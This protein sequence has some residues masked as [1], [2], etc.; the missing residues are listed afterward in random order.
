[1]DP[2]NEEPAVIRGA[3]DA[4]LVSELLARFGWPLL[5]LCALLYFTVRRATPWLRW[6][7]SSSTS[8]S[9]PDLLMNMHSAMELS[10]IRMQQ[11]LDARAAEHQ[12]RVKQLEEERQKQKMESWERGRS[13]RPRRDPQSQ[14]EENSTSSTSLPR[15]E[16]HRLRDNNYSPLS[17]GGGPTCLWRPGRRGPASGGG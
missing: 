6:G 7:R 4:A 17:G 1:M 3:S 8:I 14:Q 9:N 13:L 5:L 16:R 12:A 15:T 11:E 10:R 2:R